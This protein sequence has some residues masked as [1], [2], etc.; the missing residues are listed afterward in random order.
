MSLAVTCTITRS[1]AA[2]VT[3]TF[4]EVVAEDILPK[5][6]LAST[7]LPGVVGTG[8]Y[9]GRWDT[10]GSRREIS[11]TDGSTAREQVTEWI[12]PGRF[13]YR[14]DSFTNILGRM[15]T[16]ATGEWGFWPRA[17]GSGFT[18]TYTFHARSR[19]VEPILRLFVATLWR[20]YMR[21]CADRCVQLAE[22]TAA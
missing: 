20:G 10:A 7:L 9:T 11:F 13:A 8:G 19:V 15:V 5:V 6:L 4:D 2:E 21:R 1:V 22:H 18:W 12:R 3:R 14:V 16:H 17:T